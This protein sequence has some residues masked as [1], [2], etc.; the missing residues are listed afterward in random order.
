MMK[1]KMNLTAGLL[2]AA[3]LALPANAAPPSVGQPAPDFTL[4]DSHGAAHKLSDLKGKFVVLEWVNF[5]CPFV[6]KHYG[7]GHMQEL[8]KTYTGKGVVWL[9]VNSSAPG[10]D[11]NFAPAEIDKKTR[12]RG[13]APTAYLIDADGTVGR[14]YGARTTP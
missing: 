6:G 7:S 8:Q 2:G 14:A 10:K 11:G 12:E 5:N 9:S 4:N 13:A 3:L 1:W